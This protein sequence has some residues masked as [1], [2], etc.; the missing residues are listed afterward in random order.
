MW[1]P[2]CEVF[3]PDAEKRKEDIN[4]KDSEPNCMCENKKDNVRTEPMFNLILHELPDRNIK[5]KVSA[6]RLNSAISYLSKY[7]TIEIE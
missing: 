5:I 4:M 7:F 2:F 6:S 1:A 3:S